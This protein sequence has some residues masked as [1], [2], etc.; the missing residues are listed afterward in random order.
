MSDSPAQNTGQYL[1]SPAERIREQVRLYE[2]TN[3]AEGGTLEGRPVII[4]THIGAKSGGTRKIPIMRIP[5]D[6]AY[7][8]VASAAGAPQHPAWYFNLL[9]HPQ[10]HVQ[11]G[12]WHRDLVA[13]EVRGH[14]KERLWKVAERYWPHFPEYRAKAEGREIPIFRLE[15]LRSGGVQEEGDLER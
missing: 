2:A 12:E 1:P 5:D 9:A 11:D 8:A 10:V 7:V 6:D 14:E 15:T 3:G 4:L 13:R